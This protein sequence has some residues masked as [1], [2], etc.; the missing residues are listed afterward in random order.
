MFANFVQLGYG[1]AERSTA[2]RAACTLLRSPRNF[3]LNL[4][5]QSGCEVVESFLG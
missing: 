2:R 4:F 5:T 1:V 3:T